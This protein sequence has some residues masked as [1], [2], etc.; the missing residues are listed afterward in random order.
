MRLLCA[1]VT[2]ISKEIPWTKSTGLWTDERASVHGSTVDRSG[3]PFRVLIWSVHF[4]FNGWEEGGR[5]NNGC[6]QHGQATRRRGHRRPTG[7]GLLWPG[8][9]C[10]LAGS[11]REN[12][13]TRSGAGEE[14]RRAGEVR[15]SSGAVEV[16]F[17]GS[18]KKKT[19]S[20]KYVKGTH[21]P[22]G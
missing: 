6:G 1:K 11:K 17:I 22:S 10:G 5:G 4:G 8:D 7:I 3:Y 16:A 2:G 14:E 18:L 15:H 19:S 13:G 20:A 9:H 21:R 12:W